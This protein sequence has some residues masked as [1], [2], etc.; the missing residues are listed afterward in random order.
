IDMTN[1]G[2]YKRNKKKRAKLMKD[3][4]RGYLLLQTYMT[5]SLSSV[6]YDCIEDE[7]DSEDDEEDCDYVDEVASKRLPDSWDPEEIHMLR[8][9]WKEMLEYGHDVFHAGRTNE[10]LSS[11]SV[12][13]HRPKTH[14]FGAPSKRPTQGVAAGEEG[15]WKP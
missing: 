1:K 13:S 7:N 9:P 2:N 11:T 12:T 3:K 5:S 10:D 8:K 6:L 4:A 15:T 14:R